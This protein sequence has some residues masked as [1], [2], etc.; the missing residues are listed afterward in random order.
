MDQTLVGF[1]R[2]L[3]AAGTP[4]SVAEA[5]DAARAVALVGYA[6]R[7]RLKSTL[8]LV[9]AK[10][11]TDKA[12]HD[13]VFDRYFGWSGETARPADRDA[14]AG[15]PQPAAS[16]SALAA[17]LE[18]AAEG[19][20]LQL[21]LALGRAARAAG[22]D[23][24]RFESQIPFFTRRLLDELGTAPLDA[25]LTQ[26]R[27][28]EGQSEA[29]DEVLPEAPSELQRLTALR[30]RL[31]QQARAIVEQRFELYGRPATEAFM[32]GVVVE[33]SLGRLSP[34]DMARMTAAVSRMARR[35][36]VRHSR[37]RRVQLRGQLDFRRTLRAGAGHDGVPFA[38]HFKHRRRDKPRF[39]VVCDVSGSVAAHVRFLL[40]FLYALQGTV[41]DLRSFAFSHQLQDVGPVLAALPFDD[42]IALILRE[43]GGGATDYGRA[44]ADL[45]SQHWD[46]I[47][48]RTTVLILGDGRS[49][50]AD[51]RLDLFAELAE[52]AKRVLWLCPE[53][54]RRWGS[55]DSCML[56]YRPF[57][58]TVSHCASAADLERAVDD[59]LLAY[60]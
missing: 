6:D 60:G 53:P 55:G 41:A 17:L 36:A 34:P 27:S 52:R 35:L 7:E 33:R 19:Q 40:L 9:L 25:R 49:N 44:L 16:G 18:L 26:L 11:A 20:Q 32:T 56:Q 21:A 57:C 29:Q 51:P 5:I 1:V 31:R 8:A 48:K 28:A 15:L 10:S 2:A 23:E 58:T 4:A 39:V 47:D 13:Q 3:R 38:L 42:A 54:P 37:R 59:A 22:V 45:E 46:C 14:G 30:D 50:H 24:I 12:L 43:V